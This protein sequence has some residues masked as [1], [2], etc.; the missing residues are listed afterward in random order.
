[1]STCRTQYMYFGLVTINI[2]CHYS[3]FTAIIAPCALR[4]KMSIWRLINLMLS[5]SVTI[6]HIKH[7][8]TWEYEFASIFMSCYIEVFRTETIE[9]QLA[10]LLFL[11]CI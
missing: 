4:N 9:W 2:V 1:M 7:V 8:E 10:N 6:Y 11:F 3:D 5:S